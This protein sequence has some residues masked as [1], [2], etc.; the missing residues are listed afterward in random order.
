M[1]WTG[2]RVILDAQGQIVNQGNEGFANVITDRSLVAAA[3]H[4]DLATVA[5]GAPARLR[6]SASVWDGQAVTAYQWEQLSGSPLGLSTPLS[7]ETDASLGSSGPQ[8]VGDAVLQLTVTDI[9]EIAIAS[10]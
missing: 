3:D 8:P 2:E 5:A 7:A 1:T 6:G 4:S 10:G 9:L